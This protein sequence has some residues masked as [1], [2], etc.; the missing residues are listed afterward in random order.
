MNTSEPTD[1]DAGVPIIISGLRKNFGVK[2]ALA[3]FSLRL[4]CGQIYGAVGANGGG[5]TYRDA[6]PRRAVASRCWPGPS[7][8]R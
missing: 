8:G 6:H 4:D 3:D 1:A 5:K 7:V 2:V